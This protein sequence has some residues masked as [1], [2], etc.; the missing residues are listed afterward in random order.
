MCGADLPEWCGA[1]VAGAPVLLAFALRVR[2]LH[3]TAFGLARA[4]QH[5]QQ[6]QAGGP[7]PTDIQATTQQSISELC[8]FCIASE[9]P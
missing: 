8:Y 3:C 7:T 5:L 9:Q 4:L 6:L 2:W 1:L